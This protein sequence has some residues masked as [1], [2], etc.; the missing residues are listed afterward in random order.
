MPDIDAL[1]VFIGWASG[2]IGV[3]IGLR[4]FDRR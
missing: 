3:A 1:S 4:W 2:V